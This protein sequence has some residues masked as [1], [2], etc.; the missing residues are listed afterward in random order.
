MSAELD[1]D[2]KAVLDQL[3]PEER[4]ALE[5]DD[6]SPE[7][8][9][10]VA[11]IA[12]ADDESD[13]GD[14]GDDDGDDDATDTR[15]AGKGEEG[16]DKGGKPDVKATDAAI[17]DGDGVDDDDAPAPFKPQFKVELPDDLD[18]QIAALNTQESDLAKQMKDGE[19]ELAEFL[20]KQR[21]ISK[22]VAKLESKRDQAQAFE[23]MNR[24]TLEQEWNWTVE[25]FFRK[26]R[27][28]EGI[29]YRADKEKGGDFDLFVKTLASKPE[30]Q[31]KPFDWYLNEA[32]KRTKALHGIASKQAAA[33]PAPRDKDG[34]PAKRTPPVKDLPATLANVPGGDGPG[35]VGDNEFADLDKLEGLEY[36]TALASM[37]K[38]Q[39]DRYLQAA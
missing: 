8:R 21:D 29:D 2:R 37:S 30:N 5:E 14:D 23:E 20:E 33:D 27:R 38:E 10:A 13:D 15:A 28:D 24:Q 17:P 39:R 6:L 25:K 12:G 31:D 32:H 3:S 4:A 35:D 18:D 16:D 11:K 36:E 1:A 9:A 34:K 26:I 19:I 22:Q 7:D